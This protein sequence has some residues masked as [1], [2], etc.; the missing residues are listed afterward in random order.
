[1]EMGLKVEAP[2]V[3][4]HCGWA[5]GGLGMEMGLKFDEIWA[6]TGRAGLELG[7]E[8]KRD[9]IGWGRSWIQ[10]LG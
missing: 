9:V 6:G 4:L 3:K 7:L 5:G 8:L 1:M 10:W 2:V